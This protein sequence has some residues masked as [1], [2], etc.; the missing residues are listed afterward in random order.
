MIEESTFSENSGFLVV[1]VCCVSS[2]ELD[3]KLLGRERERERERERGRE[4][5]RV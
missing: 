2:V 4:R 5:E 1:E 3:R